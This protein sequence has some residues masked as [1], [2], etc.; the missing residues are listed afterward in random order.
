MLLGNLRSQP[1]RNPLL[2]LPVAR[3]PN[4]HRR[5]RGSE[6]AACL[7]H[8]VA[9]V[10]VAN[11]HP[12]HQHLPGVWLRSLEETQRKGIADLRALVEIAPFLHGRVGELRALERPQAVDRQT[13]SAAAMV[14]S[15]ALVYRRCSPRHVS[16][17]RS[18]NQSCHPGCR[19]GSE[20]LGSTPSQRR[21]QYGH[22]ADVQ[23]RRM[24]PIR[25]TQGFQVIGSGIHLLENGTVGTV[26]EVDL[27]EG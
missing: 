12:A 7:V 15:W 3:T 23:R 8:R 6:S 27:A 19:C 4:T 17:R 21:G 11:A 5:Q 1:R 20:Y 25:L 13:R 2:L 26:Q 22:L 14:S 18:G 10:V 16:H 24:L 9:A